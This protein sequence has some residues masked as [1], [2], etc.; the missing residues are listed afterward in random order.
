MVNI[1]VAL[2]VYRPDMRFLREALDSVYAQRGT[3]A[4]NVTV[5]DD[6]G[7]DADALRREYPGLRYERNPERLG[8]VGNWNRCTTRCGGDLVLLMGQDDRL[9]PGM[10]EAYVRAFEEDGGVVACASG[11]SFI[12]QAGRTVRPRRWVNDR[13][14]IFLA[15][16][17][18]RLTHDDVL[19]LCL[20]YGNAIGEPA[21]VMYRRSALTRLQGYD[22]AYTHAADVEFNLRLSSFGDI[23]YFRTPYLA[24]RLHDAQATHA[25]RKSGQAGADRVR[26]YEQYAEHLPEVERAAARFHL[27]CGDAR[28]ML[29]AASHWQWGQLRHTALQLLRHTRIPLRTY[30]QGGA[31][32]L[33]GRNQSAR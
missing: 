11:R 31:E 4:V 13:A 7:T 25:N 33:T 10:F 28:D 12:D 6:G 2:P 18:Y 9:Q 3:F 27:L 23:V 32:L 8:M 15:R 1:G 16:E 30:L 21:C 5:C 17:R 22:P 20:R 19:Q 14:R 29:S 26:L 24:R